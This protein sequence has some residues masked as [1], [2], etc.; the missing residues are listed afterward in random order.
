VR[1]GAIFPGT[2]D[3]EAAHGVCIALIL[4]TALVCLHVHVG[5]GILFVSLVERPMRPTALL[6][7]HA[8]K[9]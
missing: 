6:T 5:I 1:E 7:F 8:I 2:S 9:Q 4:G 3:I